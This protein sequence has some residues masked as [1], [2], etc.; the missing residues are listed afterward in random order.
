MNEIKFN[1][2]YAKLHN[3]TLGKLIDVEV[4]SGRDLDDRF[5]AYDTE[6]SYQLDLTKEYLVLY[7]SGLKR[8]PF[9]TIRKNNI[10]NQMKYFPNTNKWFKII[11]EEN[12][13]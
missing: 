4:V 1:K 13:K 10:E 2:N 6:N 7:F 8:I 3:Q 9:T 12:L 5:I 11:I